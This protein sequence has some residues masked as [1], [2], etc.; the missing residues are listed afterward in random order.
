MSRSIL[1]SKVECLMLEDIAKYSRR[2][3]I[4]CLREWIQKEYSKIKK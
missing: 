4:D 1:L 3:P 2:K